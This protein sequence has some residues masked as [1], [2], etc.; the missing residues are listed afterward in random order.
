MACSTHTAALE[1]PAL[2]FSGALGSGVVTAQ[3]IYW[4]D[5]EKVLFIGGL[6]AKMAAGSASRTALLEWNTRTGEVRVHAELGEYSGLCFDDGYVR[7]H[8]KKDGEFVV[9]AG[10]LGREVDVPNRI[11][12]TVMLNE[13]TCR[14]YDS[15]QLKESVGRGFFPLKDEHGY[16]GREPKE[17]E[18]GSI[19]LKKEEGKLRRYSLSTHGVDYP[20]TWS[21][22]AQ[23]YVLRRGERLFS[24]TRTSGKLW[25][26]SPTGTITAYQIPPGPW[27]AGA[28]RYGITKT[29][30]FVS[31]TASA[32]DGGGYVMNERG[33]LS[34]V[35]AGYI[36]SFD[37]SPDGCKVAASVRA[38]VARGE[39]PKVV[40][41]NICQLGG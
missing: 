29:G 23:A 22:F 37:I 20:I 8:F 11:T 9:K 33:Q 10:E 27:F 31:S 7:Y 16:W 3:T 6:P 4:I 28:T 24:P 40:A 15:D 19:Y 2:R 12:R 41:V 17:H 1:Q 25:L 14:E 35:V 36:H 38:S 30:V 13:F 18:R 32:G 34:K 21:R 26:L 39:S 5:D